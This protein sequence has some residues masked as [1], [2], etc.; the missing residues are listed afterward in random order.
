MRV[1]E[2][3]LQLLISGSWKSFSFFLFFL[4]EGGGFFSPP[5]RNGKACENLRSGSNF[6]TVQSAAGLDPLQSI[7]RKLMDLKVILSCVA[8]YLQDVRKLSEYLDLKKKNQPL[9]FLY[10]QLICYLYLFNMLFDNMLLTQFV[11]TLKVSISIFPISRQIIHSKSDTVCGIC[12]SVSKNLRKNC[13]NRDKSVRKCIKC[14]KCIKM[15][16]N[17]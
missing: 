15:H 1:S 17:A 8:I 16:K 5:Q 7:K 11:F 12:F 14:K 10:S 2:A 4:G 6:K 3:W 9:F 13:A